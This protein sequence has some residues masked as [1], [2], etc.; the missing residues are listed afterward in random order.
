MSDSTTTRTFAA[1]RAVLADVRRFVA[2]EAERLSFSDHAHDLQ[3]AVNE[4]CA[5][6]ILHS[7]TREIRVSIG[8]VGACL[9]IAVEDDGIY[10]DKLP[11]PEVDREGHRGIPLMAAMV[12][13]F[14]LRRG[15]EERRGTLVQFVKCKS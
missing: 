14:T 8:L 4:A 2:A 13:K 5:N 7:Q 6:A 12:D 1:D 15:T 9:Q 3:L 10:R 11:V